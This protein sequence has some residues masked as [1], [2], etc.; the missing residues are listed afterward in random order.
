M[1]HSI[2]IGLLAAVGCIAIAG[3]A[4]ETRAWVQKSNKAAMP[5]L[6]Y[7]TNYT[8]ENGS[9]IGIDQAD[10]S[11][12]D[13]KPNLYARSKKDGEKIVQQLHAKEATESDPNVLRDLEIL[14]AAQKNS[15]ETA[16]LNQELMVPFYDVG[17]IVFQGL[18]ALLDPR[19]SAGRQA[20]AIVRLN[21]YAAAET[22]FEAITELAKARTEAMLGN[23]KLVRPY[24]SEVNDAINSTQ[25][26][27]VGIGELLRTAKI[28]GWEQGHDAL[29]RQL[30]DYKQWLQKQILPQ[31]RQT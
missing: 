6:E 24:V 7:I 8:P 18:Q 5:L 31:A 30:L 22:G 27:L 15:L 11:V 1:T 12:V 26:Y 13:L 3:Y 28:T 4:G 16:R 2:R 29:S 14:I 10:E 20:S 25:T 17:Q 9:S 19:N 21:L 23:A